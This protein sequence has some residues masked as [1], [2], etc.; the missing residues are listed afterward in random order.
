LMRPKNSPCLSLY[1]MIVSPVFGLRQS[2]T[3]NTV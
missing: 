3:M 2:L 1:V